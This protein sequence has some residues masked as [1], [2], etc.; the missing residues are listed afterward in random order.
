MKEYINSNLYCKQVFGCKVYK[1]ALSAAK[2][3]PNRDGLKGTGGCIFCS[4]SG[5]GDFASNSDSS[6]KKQILSAKALLGE[7]G[8]GCKYIAYFQSFS[9]TYG[10]IEELEEVYTEAINEKDIVGI[11]IATRPDCLGKKELSMLKRLSKKTLLWV[12]LGLQTVHKETA[13]YINRCY[14]LS[15]YDEA[16]SKLREINC[17]IITHIILGLPGESRE[18]M[19]QTVKYVGEKT[20][21]IKLQLLH[22]LKN[23]KIANDYYSGKFNVLTLNE[24]CDII[25]ECIEI[26]PD[27]IVIHRMTGDGPKKDLIAPLWSGDKKRVLNTLNRVL[28][29]N[30]IKL[31]KDCD[32]I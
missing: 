13:E 7:K 23:T 19:L 28:R 12:E 10:D 1:L 26:L 22:I 5:S 8:K 4:E 30:G 9:G 21:G 18:D 31:K 3:C 24:Y 16:I 15:V 32:E 11:S 6:V 2:T 27:N 29:E 14:E 25:A 17:H 20:D